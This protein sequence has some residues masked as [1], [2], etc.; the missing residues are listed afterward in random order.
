MTS[1]A[2][3]EWRNSNNN[4]ILRYCII[5]NRYIT[6]CLRSLS[7]RVFLRLRAVHLGSADKLVR[8]L[9]HRRHELP[10]I[11]VSPN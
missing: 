10:E 1:L 6:M 2:R 7:G 4:E 11:Y 3:A 5:D 8:L 9:L